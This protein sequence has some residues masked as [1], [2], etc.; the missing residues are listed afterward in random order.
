MI[1]FQRPAQHGQH[2]QPRDQVGEGEQDVGQAHQG[3]LDLAAEVAGD[4]PDRGAEGGPEED[5]EDADL[6]R[7]P[8][9]VDDAGEDVAPLVVEPERVGGVRRPE[10]VADAL[11]ERVVGGDQ[12]AATA[13]SRIRRI[14]TRPITAVRLLAKERRARCRCETSWGPP[15]GSD[16]IGAAASAASVA[17]AWAI[18]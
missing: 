15:T 1:I 8:G 7:D 5:R 11:V 16:G 3:A 2:Q 9:A 17:V 14:R 13:T 10:A 6:E 4:D 18:S 12:G